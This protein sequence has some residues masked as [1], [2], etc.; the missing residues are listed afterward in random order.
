MTRGSFS[1]GGYHYPHIPMTPA[2]LA[3]VERQI[4]YLRK[5]I[6]GRTWTEWF[7]SLVCFSVTDFEKTQLRVYEDTLVMNTMYLQE[8]ECQPPNNP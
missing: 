5:R 4:T 8:D 7:L 6:E 2:D 1:R 3:F